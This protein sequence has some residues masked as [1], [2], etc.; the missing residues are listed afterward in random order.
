ME[1]PITFREN[2]LAGRG[3]PLPVPCAALC[4][5]VLVIRVGDIVVV[6]ARRKLV[7]V[8]VE[9][10]SVYSSG[11]EVTFRIW[12]TRFRKDGLP[13]KRTKQFWIVV[14]ND[15]EPEQKS[16]VRQTRPRRG[17]VVGYGN[18]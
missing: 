15:L 16:L 2:L 7:R 18:D 8:E 6:E 11:P 9:G 3:H 4:E 1:S 12:R 5:D 17:A 10:M 13:G 14:E